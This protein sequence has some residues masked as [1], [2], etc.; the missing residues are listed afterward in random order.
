ME[1]V[2]RVSLV[3]ENLERMLVLGLLPGDDFLPSAAT[4]GVAK[5]RVCIEA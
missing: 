1:R 3:E 4:A 2:G 5:V